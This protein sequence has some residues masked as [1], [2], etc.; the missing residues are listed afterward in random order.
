M[1]KMNRD[2][3]S[4]IELMIAV[5]LTAIVLAGLLALLGYGTHNMR[6]TQALVALQ[7]Q[8][9][10]ATNH[11]STYT[12]EASDIEWDEDSNILVV[13]KESVPQEVDAEGNYPAPVV[14]QC[15]YWKGQD[16]DGVGGIYFA[17]RDKVVDPVDNTKVNLEAKPEFLLVDDIQDFQC[18]VNEN[19]DTGKKVLHIELQL[20]N[21]ETK[22]TCQKDVYM[23]NQISAR[24]M[25]NPSEGGG[26]GV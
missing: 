14:E 4:L 9:K 25:K 13:T 18:N 3:Y 6:I 19:Q 2:G 1:K 15:Y 23:R 5:T 20:E 12:M 22:F 11:I 26:S 17:K 16:A 10:D 21:D 24:A 7:N 8:A